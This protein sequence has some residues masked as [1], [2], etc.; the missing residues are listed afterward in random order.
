MSA[1][2]D[3]LH[4][5]YPRAAGLVLAD[6]LEKLQSAHEPLEAHLFG[7]FHTKR[8]RLR[9]LAGISHLTAYQD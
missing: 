6:I 2:W 4:K 3:L 9:L 1:V 7:P 8:I 5:A